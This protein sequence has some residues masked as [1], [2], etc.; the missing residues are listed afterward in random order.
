MMPSFDIP[1]SFGVPGFRIPDEPP[2]LCKA[3]FPLCCLIGSHIMS[4]VLIYILII[5]VTALHN[6]LSLGSLNSQNWAESVMMN[7]V[8][9]LQW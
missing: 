7:N 6:C 2:V 1:L 4:R 5:I 8:Y 9:Y 3:V